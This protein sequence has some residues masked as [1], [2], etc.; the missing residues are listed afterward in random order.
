[1]RRGGQLH[2]THPFYILA[3]VIL[4]NDTI[5]QYGMVQ[6]GGRAIG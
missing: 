1:M 3:I 4:R 2:Q 5:D 6:T